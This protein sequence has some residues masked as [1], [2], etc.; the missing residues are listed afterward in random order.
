MGSLSMIVRPATPEDIPE[1][2]RLAAIMYASMGQAP[3]QDWYEEAGRVLAA[4]L[5]GEDL[6]V[7]VADAGEPGRLASCVA[8]VVGDR[9]PGATNPG[10]FR[11]AYVQWMSTDP[12]YR[13]RGLAREALTALLAW[14]RARGVTAVELHATTEGEPLYRSLGFEPPPC[15]QLRLSLSRKPPGAAVPQHPGGNSLSGAPPGT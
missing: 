1:V 8:G 14:L 9:L 3:R 5:G 7:F 2:L 11:A 12:G 13:R 15:P 4:R 6:A 10:S